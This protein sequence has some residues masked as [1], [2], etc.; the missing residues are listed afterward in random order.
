MADW[1]TTANAAAAQAT[2]RRDRLPQL[3]LAVR[4]SAFV[5]R[6]QGL[7]VLEARASPRTPPGAT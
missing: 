4:T 1:A 6:T 7:F 5:A 3:A 2:L